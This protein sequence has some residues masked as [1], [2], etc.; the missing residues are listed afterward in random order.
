MITFLRK[1]FIKNYQDT[2]SPKVREAHGILASCG[3]V[4]INL[5]LF[6]FKLVIGII[7]LSMSVI[8][9]AINNLT[10]FFSCIVNLI[11]F[12]VAS[13]PADKNHP[14]GHERIEYLSG[15]IISFVIV[16]CG[17]LLIYSSVSTL[18][19][20]QSEISI[21]IY[22]FIILGVS[23][24]VKLLLGLFYRGL[25]KVINSVSLKA[26]M[27]DSINDVIVT[28]FVL[29]SSII[30][31]FY[32]SL[33]YLDASVSIVVA[34]FVLFAGAKMIK[35][36]SAPL[37]GV[38]P[39]ASNV[40]SIKEEVLKIDGVIG[41]H[42]MLF[43]S[44]GPTK[45]YL[46][47]H[48]EVN[49]NLNLFSAHDIADNVEH[50]INEKFSIDATVHIDPIDVESKEYQK[51]SLDLKNILLD[52][53]KDF[54]FH[55]LRIVKTHGGN[56]ICFDIALPIDTKCDKDKLTQNIKTK[57]NGEYKDYEID[58]NIDDNYMG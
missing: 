15:L 1:L 18:M 57:L 58:I 47:L 22:T 28:S 42:D 29:I 6:T 34:L 54:T 4:I 43:H 20:G 23:I 56:R 50:F 39:E 37:I 24:L 44:Y 25:G 36:T 33:W 10:D 16:A 40:L 12:K 13:K 3:G 27:Q 51:L 55:D 46:T 14:F 30:Q 49:G 11:G 17:L 7:T 21:N 26:A 41:V 45:V 2:N 53:N 52:I 19:E 31:Y 5:I 9:D 8:S 38:R 32:P 35:E 48:I